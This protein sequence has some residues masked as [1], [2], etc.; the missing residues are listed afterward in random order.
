MNLAKPK[1]VATFFSYGMAEGLKQNN[2]DVYAI[3]QENVQNKEQWNE[4][5][6]S[7]HIYYTQLN[8]DIESHI[9]QVWEFWTC[10]I[11]R[12]NEYFKNI[13]FDVALT[14]FFAN[15]STLYFP[16]IK[17]RYRIAVCH[18][19]FPHSGEGRINAFLAKRYYKQNDKLI[20]LTDKFRLQASKRYNK[21]NQDI[22]V[23][24]HGRLN[25][26]SSLASKEP[27]KYY[28]SESINFLFFGR[29]QKYKGIEVL[30]KAFKLLVN[31]KKNVTLTI[32]GNGDF[33]PYKQLYDS[34]PNVNLLIRYIDDSEVEG[35]FKSEKVVAVVPYLDATQSGVIPI[36]ME[37]GV[38]II[39]SETGG[40][41]EQLDNGKIGLFF[42]RGNENDL[43]RK[44]MSIVDNPD[45]F[46]CQRKLEYDYIECLN[47]DKVMGD[48]LKQI[49]YDKR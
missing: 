42:E 40:L 22:I 45:I 49:S 13:V 6:P 19:P 2:I 39:A 35:L 7:N 1:E 28:D 25:V 12:L 4:L 48:F 27:K 30:G 34:L 9:K 20:V 11:K 15:W 14:T 24:P 8:N 21:K 26:Y 37:Y 29:I 31:K 36:A 38:P 47:W 3:M 46:T 32:A 18:D 23:I 5:L 10:E 41:K 44:M 16:L 33:S 17:A 43:A